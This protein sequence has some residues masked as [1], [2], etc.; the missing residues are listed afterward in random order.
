[1]SKDTRSVESSS[2]LITEPLL[3]QLRHSRPKSPPPNPQQN[4]KYGQQSIRFCYCCYYKWTIQKF[5]WHLR[6]SWKRKSQLCFI[7]GAAESCTLCP[8]VSHPSAILSRRLVTLMQP[9][10]CIQTQTCVGGN[11]GPLPALQHITV[12][13]QCHFLCN[14][15]K[16]WISFDIK[17]RKALR[18][19][20]KPLTTKSTGKSFW[21]I[22][23]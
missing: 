3:L 9:D 17:G 18:S 13:G 20:M 7:L 5:E 19:I 16:W 2:L 15:S 11:G 4:I 1:M 10:V 22:C 12:W 23:Y 6:D 21:M 8:A 14:P